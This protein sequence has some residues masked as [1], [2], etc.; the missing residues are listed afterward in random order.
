VNSNK[1]QKAKIISLWSKTKCL[2]FKNSLL[3]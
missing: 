2:F 3:V 1:K